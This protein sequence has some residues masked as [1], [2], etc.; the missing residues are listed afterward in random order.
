M[1]Y[2]AT[3][4]QNALNKQG[5]NLA[6]D[7]IIGPKTT[8]AIKDY[9]QKNSLTV[10]GIVGEQTWGALNKAQTS[11]A[12]EPAQT[13]TPAAP[14]Q[15]APKF[16]Y[17]PS[18]TVSQAEALLR[19]QLAQK[20]GEYQSTWSSQLNDIIKQIQN[21]KEFSYDLNGDAMYQ[22]YRDQYTT[23][24]KLASMDAIGQAAAMTGGYGNSFAQTAGQ[25]AYQSYLQKLNEVVPELYGMA[26]DQHNQEQQALYDQAGLLASMEDQEYGRYR[27]QMSDYYTEL[28]R[29]TEDARYM[30]ET[31]YQKAM[32]DFNIK[33]GAYRD[34]VGDQ[35][36][37]AQFDEAKRQYDEQM[38]VS[39][40][41]SSGGD[42]GNVGNDTYTANPGWDEEKVRAFQEAHDLTVDGIWG[43]KTAAAYD[44]DPNWEPAPTYNSIVDDLN[45]YI[46]NGASKSNINT[47]LRSAYQAGYI[48][49]AEYN[50]LKNQ[51]A[52]AGNTY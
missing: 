15:E 8:A 36:W 40:S 18:D 25:Q 51:F 12:Q 19:Q 14:Q 42:Q 24:G 30:S 32:D 31:E 41:K 29:L 33:Y 4:I 3:D 11:A 34:T 43:P 37:Q 39:K 5:Y 38:A 23:Q 2:K 45:T 52:P 22:Q 46:K 6:V 20:P 44:E 50:K 10:D 27:D 7:G 35:Q 47:Y 17:K 13:T 49:Q 1:A 28:N 21:G 26:R 48:T 9:Q 16:E